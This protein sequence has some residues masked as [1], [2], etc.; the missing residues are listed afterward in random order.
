MTV[1]RIAAAM[2]AA[3]APVATAPAM[4]DAVMPGTVTVEPLPDGVVSPEASR[5]F[6][7]A[8]ERALNDADFLA[9]PAD[10]RGRYIARMKL[11]RHAQGSVAV[12]AAE[13]GMA[14]DFGDWGARF[15][16]TLPSGK[17]HIRGLIVTELEIEVLRRDGM[18]PV[19]SGRALTV[20][21]QGTP[22]DAP[23]AVAKK[24]A[25]AVMRVFPEQMAEPVSVP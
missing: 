10:N 1:L 23:A 3:L 11:S 22:G 7:E 14:S 5:L 24:L 9:L 19:W 18:Q 17:R 25:D 4:Q 13:Q 20:K 8:V 6:A 2:L 21:P 12:N 15:L 16:V